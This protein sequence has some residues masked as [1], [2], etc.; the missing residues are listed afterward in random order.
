MFLL[1]ILRTLSIVVDKGEA[2]GLMSW[3]KTV[4]SKWETEGTAIVKP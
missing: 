1:Y 4:L 2:L 3:D